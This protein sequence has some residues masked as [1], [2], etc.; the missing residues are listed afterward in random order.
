MRYLVSWSMS[1]YKKVTGVSMPLTL[2]YRITCRATFINLSNFIPRLRSYLIVWNL[3][4]PKCVLLA[5]R[6]MLC[7]FLKFS[8]DYVNLIACT[9]VKWG[10]TEGIEREKTLSEKYTVIFLDFWRY[11]LFLVFQIWG[12]NT[13]GG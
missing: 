7:N 9:V 2:E 10:H 8:I 5:E 6:A 13:F 12:Q 11:K 4:H 3:S 1:F